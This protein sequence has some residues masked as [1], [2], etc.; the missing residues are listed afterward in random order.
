[1]NFTKLSVF[2]LVFFFM[3]ACSPGQLQNVVKDVI[4][5]VPLTNG[6]IGNGLKEALEKALL[7]ELLNFL[8]SMVILKVL[9]RSYYH[10]KLVRLPIS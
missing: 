7:K 3:T 4:S 5:D 2:G 6:Q 9:I 8:L 10:Q 1:M